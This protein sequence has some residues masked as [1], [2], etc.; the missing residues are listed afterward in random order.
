MRTRKK[1]GKCN[2]GGTLWEYEN[3]R[4]GSIVGSTVK[5]NKCGAGDIFGTGAEKKV[6]EVIKALATEEGW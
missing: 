5:C 6:K 2:C 4:H 1:V 3:I